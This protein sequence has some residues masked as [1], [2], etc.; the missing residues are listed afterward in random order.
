MPFILK[1]DIFNPSIKK[2]LL[3]YLKEK[4]TYYKIKYYKEI[5]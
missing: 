5:Y 2:R 1:E 4:G 3:S